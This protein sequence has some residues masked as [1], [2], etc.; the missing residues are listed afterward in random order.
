MLA[1][2]GLLSLCLCTCPRY[3]QR[4]VV[5]TLQALLTPFGNDRRCLSLSPGCQGYLICGDSR[6][7]RRFLTSG[8]SSKGDVIRRP[9]LT[10]S[11]DERLYCHVCIQRHCHPW[12][13]TTGRASTPGIQRSIISCTILKSIHFVHLLFFINKH[14]RPSRDRKYTSDQIEVSALLLN[15]FCSTSSSTPENVLCT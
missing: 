14:T 9:W 15:T 1:F 5:P 13:V 7:G 12:V 3:V 10:R 8:F 6:P 4:L 11:F 2:L